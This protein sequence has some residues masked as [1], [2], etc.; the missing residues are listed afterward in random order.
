[1]LPNPF[2]KPNEALSTA[3]TVQRFTHSEAKL[4]IPNIINEA[5]SAT[6]LQLFVGRK[7]SVF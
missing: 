1:M 4:K 7:I 6:Y 2:T 3:K 5:K